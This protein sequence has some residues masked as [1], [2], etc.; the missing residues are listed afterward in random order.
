MA[1]LK[2]KCA[3]FGVS[4]HQDAAYI[5]SIG[6]AALNHRGQDGSGITSTDGRKMR[7][8]KGKGLVN[9]VYASDPWNTL[10]GDTAVG[11]NRY[12]TSEGS[13]ESDDHLGPITQVRRKGI[14]R[15]RPTIAIAVNGNNP[16]TTALEN[17]LRQIGRFSPR[18]NDTEMEHAL[19][20]YH[21]RNGASVEDAVIITKAIADSAYSLLAMDRKGKLVAARGPH[22]IRPLVMGELERKDG[23]ATVFSSETCALD[24][25]GAQTIREV[26]PG[27]MIV[28]EN[29]QLR[30]IQFAEGQEKIDPFEY[31]YFARPDSILKGQTIQTVRE[32]MGAKLFQEEK[33]RVDADMVIS[34]PDSGT[35]AAIGYARASGIPYRAGFVSNRYSGRTFIKPGAE[36]DTAIARKLNPMP[37]VVRGKKII[38]VEDSAVRG[39]TLKRSTRLLRGA[40]V[41]KIHIRIS[42]PEILF[43]DFFGINTPN[44]KD[45]IAFLKNVEEMRQEF[46]A[47]SLQFLSVDGM[48]D[49]IGIPRE[50]LNL[51]CFTGE[52]PMDIG[53]RREEVV[54]APQR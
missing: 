27:E 54:F 17:R 44:Q 23:K 42:S 19:I 5:T 50:N 36:I 49:A 38:L 32:R 51:S 16:D 29:G 33:T 28:V 3:V 13:S 52:Y 1:G 11:H 34:V 41:D 30:S 2:E 48:V 9:A 47:D 35:P 31:L 46:G 22:G 39:K 20:D 14:L 18:D 24:V 12:G 26:R 45:L 4:G 37:E 6:L 7:T 15:R 8:H 10:R 25:I 40:G 21:V 53:K 43:P